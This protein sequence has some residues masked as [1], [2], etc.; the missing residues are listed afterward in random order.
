MKS[1]KMASLGQLTAGVVHEVLNPLNI[2]SAHVQLLLA[3]AEKG[4]K[5]EEDLRSIREEID[6]IVEITDGLL[7]F[8]RKEK[9][10]SGEVEINSLLEKIISI[11]E[12]EMKLSNIKFIRRFEEGLPKIAANSDELRQVFLNMITNAK[13][14]MAEG[15]T[16]TVK[17]RRVRDRSKKEKASPPRRAGEL[18][19]DFVKISFEDTGCG[20]SKEKLNSVFDPFFTTKMEG[21]GTGLGLSISYGIIENHGG[22]IS[23]ESEVGK[24]TTF[25]INLPV[26]GSHLTNW[27]AGRD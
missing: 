16:L 7:R 27:R 14:A 26:K 3:E 17:T 23:V 20:I 21:K 2:I 24:G 25:I 5:T 19:G 18:K 6:R 13:G 4:S 8:S 12:P 11:V 10:I 9:S 22:T 1:H 15:G